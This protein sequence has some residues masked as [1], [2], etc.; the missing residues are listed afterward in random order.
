MKISVRVKL[1]KFYKQIT[2]II[3][4]SLTCIQ[5]INPEN[6]RNNVTTDKRALEKSL[7]FPGWGQ[8]HEKQYL[9]GGLFIAAE[10]IAIA[11]MVINNN[12]G[13]DSYINYRMAEVGNE[14]VM[15]RKET[16]KFDKRRNLFIVA[17]IG[18]W[19]ANMVE[20]YIFNKRKN[21]KRVKI[22]LIRGI[23]NEVFID[24]SYGF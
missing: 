7:L 22:S 2:V 10:V 17:G 23:N 14:A 1:S 8:I 12:K 16:E 4:F 6:K 13:N 5:L 19:I 18:I 3:I 21:K 15:W 24:L 9:K 20:I 11:G